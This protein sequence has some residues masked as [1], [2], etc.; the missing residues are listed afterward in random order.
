MDTPA[1]TL[2]LRR[3]RFALKNRHVAAITIIAPTLGV[4]G[5]SMIRPGCFG[6]AR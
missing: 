1:S 5:S 6:A 4:D 2:R 3:H